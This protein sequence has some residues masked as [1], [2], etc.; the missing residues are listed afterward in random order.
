MRRHVDLP[1]RHPSLDLSEQMRLLLFDWTQ[2]GHHADATGRYAPALSDVAAR[3]AG[4]RFAEAVPTP[5]P[6]QASGPVE[7]RRRPTT[8]LPVPQA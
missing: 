1:Q 2:G 8:R 4:E 7:R 3:F 5:F 6:G